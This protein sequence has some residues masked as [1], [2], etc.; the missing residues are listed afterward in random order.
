MVA[1]CR[2]NQITKFAFYYWKKRLQED[3][4]DTHSSFF[5]ELKLPDS[6]FRPEGKAGLQLRWRDYSFLVSNSS[7]LSLVNSFHYTLY[8]R[9]KQFQKIKISSYD[10]RCL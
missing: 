5:T 1:W 10:S 2:Q 8:K 6:A 4:V 3:T 9:R 7:K